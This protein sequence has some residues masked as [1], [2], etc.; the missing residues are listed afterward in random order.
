M[1]EL[2]LL[3]IPT[4]I[5]TNKD[6]IVE[7]IV[8]FAG[9]YIGPEDIVCVA[10]S[11]V[12][13]TQG[14]FTRPEDLILSQSN[15]PE[16]LECFKEQNT[17]KQ[18]IDI[19]VFQTIPHIEKLYLSNPQY[20]EEIYNWFEHQIKDIKIYISKSELDNQQERLEALKI[21]DNIIKGIFQKPILIQSPTKLKINTNKNVFYDLIRQ[22]K[23]EVSIEKGKCILTQT[24]EEIAKFIKDN[25][26]G[27]E[28]L[29]LNTIIKEISRDQIIKGKRIEVKVIDF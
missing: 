13:I 26:E 4:R 16:T 21:F 19:E 15:I 17:N 10:E 7:A 8:E 25:I 23:K 6:D 28:N 3:P 29:S 20:S 14:E 1:A 5:L 18:I 11:V 24:D 9:P 2:E 12:A 22:L 27:F